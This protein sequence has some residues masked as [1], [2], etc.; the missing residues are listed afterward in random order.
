[1]QSKLVHSSEVITERYVHTLNN[2]VVRTMCSY[3]EHQ[4]FGGILDSSGFSIP[5]GSAAVFEAVAV[6]ACRCYAA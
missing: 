2:R 5:R 1:M 3:T 4:D 6:G